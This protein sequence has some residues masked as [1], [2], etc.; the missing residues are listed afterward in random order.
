MVVARL[1]ELR[2]RFARL[3]TVP[4]LSTLSRWLIIIGLSLAGIGAI[5]AL[6]GRFGIP[7][8]R[9]PGDFR[10]QSGN[11]SVYIPLASAVLLS[12]L[13]SVAVNILLRL[14]RK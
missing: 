9:L 6:L 11:V 7:L 2:A 4:E 5:V 13:L 3:S 10:F 8:G 12:V 1:P 14:L